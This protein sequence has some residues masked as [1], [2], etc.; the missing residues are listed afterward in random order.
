MHGPAELLAA[1]VA[2]DPTR[3]LITYYDDTPGPTQGERVELSRRV[4][5]TWVAK[6]ANALQEGLDAE[7]G[8]LVELDLPSPHWRLAYWA[9]ATWA[10]GATVA[11]DDHEGAHVLVTTDPD[12][13]AAQD[14]DEVVAVTLPAL[15]RSFAA[16]A[17][18]RTGVMDEA[19][20]LA[21]YGDGFTAWDEPDE[22]DDALACEGERTTYEQ[23]LPQLSWPAGARVLTTSSV[24]LRFLQHLLHV[25]AVGGS[26]VAVRGA[27]VGA[28]DPRVA[29]EGVDLLADG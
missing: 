10:V 6:A 12:S 8:S 11:L 7:P 28:D 2:E 9:V 18:L 21:S 29:A 23:L 25:L 16:A 1:L 3:P 20:E 14:A 24:P 17:E 4:F 13:P 5:G 26:L 27:T 22:D 15:A 19:H